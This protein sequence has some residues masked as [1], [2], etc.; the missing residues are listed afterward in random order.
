LLALDPKESGHFFMFV[1]DHTALSHAEHPIL[2]ID[3]NDEVGRAFRVIPSEMWGVENN[4]S[5]SNMDFYE[6]ADNADAD[7]IFRGF[8]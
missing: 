5:I 8:D 6:F 7:G 2:V 3:L 4:L 1:V